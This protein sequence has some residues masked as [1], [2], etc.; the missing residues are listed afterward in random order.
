MKKWVPAAWIWLALM[1]GTAHAD[2]QSAREVVRTYVEAL[3]AGDLEAMAQTLSEAMISHGL[4]GVDGPVHGRD[5]Y[6]AVMAG[7]LAAFSD[8]NVE[9]HEMI[10]EGDLVAVR[11]TLTGTHTEPL[12]DIPATGRQ[13]RVDALALFR[14]EDGQIAEKWYRQDDLG[15]FQQLGLSD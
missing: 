5:A 3:S 14:V 4:L 11:W 15:M 12:G 9:V 7:N 8:L 1:V 13:V 2:T 6:V 10:A